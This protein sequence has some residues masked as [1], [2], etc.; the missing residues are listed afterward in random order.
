MSLMKSKRAT[1]LSRNTGI[2]PHE[3]DDLKF[4]ELSEIAKESAIKRQVESLQELE[5]DSD[6]II[7]DLERELEKNG[8]E[9]SSKNGSRKDIR[10]SV[11]FSQGDHFVFG[12][13]F[14]DIPKFIKNNKKSKEYALLLRFI[15]KE[16]GGFEV[17]GKVYLGA[18]GESMLKDTQVRPGSYTHRGVTSMDE[19]FR[20]DNRLTKETYLK[21]EQQCEDILEEM[22]EFCKDKAHATYRRM[23]DDIFYQFSEKA[24]IE[25]FKYFDYRFDIDGNV[26]SSN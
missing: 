15:K 11:S 2:S 17:W 16:P 14:S 21:L 19:D 3:R 7:D 25:Y 6:Y 9:I 5:F 20:K 13:Y 22:Y 4:E 26:T 10:Y 12:A 18:H 23:Y 24:A 8:I 1:N